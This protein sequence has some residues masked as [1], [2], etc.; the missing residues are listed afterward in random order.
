MWQGSYEFVVNQWGVGHGGFHSQ[1]LFLQPVRRGPTA[2]V[3]DGTL[4]RVIYDCGSGRSGRPR[5]ALKDAVAR[6]LG[7]VDDKAQIDLLVISHFDHDHVN[8][9]AYLAGEL[10]KRHIDVARVWAPVLTKIE[11]LLAIARSGLD[12]REQADYAAFLGDPRNRLEELFDRAEVTQIAASDEPIPVATS[13]AAAD[14]AD[15]ADDGSIYLRNS[16]GGRGLVAVPAASAAGEAL[17]EFQPYVIKST[18]VGASAVRASVHRLLGKSLEQCSIDDLLK[19]ASNQNIL[20]DFHSEVMKHH[21]KSAKSGVR[22]S[23]ART[24]PNLSTLCLYSGPVSP[25]EWCQFRRGWAPLS[26]TPEAIPIAPAWLGTG[27]AGLSGA[28]PVNALRSALSE[29]RLDRVGVTSVPHHGSDQDSGA[30]LWDALPN[31]RKI[32]IEANNLKG[33]TGNSHPHATVLA[34]LATR[35]LSVHVSADAH[36]FHSRGRRMR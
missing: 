19:I 28:K 6:M 25:Y 35:N 10:K 14:D 21:T 9:L 4:V 11:A 23:S 2:R 27:D 8:G 7:D 3:G 15:E 13:D 20:Q 26:V 1:S 12:G 30:P 29:S 24:S 18:L 34:E 31:V 32:T 22:A 33:G 36:D 5:K 16:P 17:W